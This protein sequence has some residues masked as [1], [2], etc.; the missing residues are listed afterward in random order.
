MSDVLRLSWFA[1]LVKEVAFCISD[2]AQKRALIKP[3]DLTG[4]V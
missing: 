2:K 4:G 1:A 3:M